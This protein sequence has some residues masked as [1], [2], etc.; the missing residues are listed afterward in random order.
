M[1]Q[2]WELGFKSKDGVAMKALLWVYQTLTLKVILNILAWKFWGIAGNRNSVSKI[3][4]SIPV[5]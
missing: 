4:N 5:I 1:I 3:T 2:I